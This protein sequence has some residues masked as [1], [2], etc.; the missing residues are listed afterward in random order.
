MDTGSPFLLVKGLETQLSSVLSALDIFSLPKAEQKLVS[1]LK[2]DIVDAR[3]DIR[4]YELSET[5]SEQLKNAVAAHKRLEH[6]RKG[7]L[8]ASEYDVFT[9]VD[10]AQL[11]AQLEQISENVR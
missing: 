9:A 7:I 2:R 11:T 10:V 4:D 8:A 5:R 1:G 3:L 6:I